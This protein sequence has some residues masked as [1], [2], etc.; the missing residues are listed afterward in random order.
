MLL[1]TTILRDRND[2][3]FWHKFVSDVHKSLRYSVCLAF[4]LFH[5]FHSKC[6]IIYFSLNNILYIFSY[7]F[8]TWFPISRAISNVT[9][10]R[11][12]LL[13][14]TTAVF[15]PI[16][17]KSALTRQTSRHKH[18]FSILRSWFRWLDGS[19]VVM[20]YSPSKDSGWWYIT[21]VGE[22]WSSPT[23]C[24]SSFNQF[25]KR[26]AFKLKFI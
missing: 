22:R 13:S 21:D 12:L 11:V 10:S 24:A 15:H 25:K 7:T 14:N 19:G 2:G 16:I 9:F 17:E 18:T 6:K 26:R 20:L 5:S 8:F 23:E 3:H 1:I 4:C